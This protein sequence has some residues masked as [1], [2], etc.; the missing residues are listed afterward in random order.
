MSSNSNRKRKKSPEP[1]NPGRTAVTKNNLQ[2]QLIV[3]RAQTTSNQTNTAGGQQNQQV[4]QTT[5]S[6]ERQTLVQEVKI[7]RKFTNKKISLTFKNITDSRK[8]KNP[9]YNST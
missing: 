6:A 2:Q 5:N 8:K 7:F 9:C 4:I 3:Q 1:T